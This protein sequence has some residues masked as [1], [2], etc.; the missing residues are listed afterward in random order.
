MLYGVQVN[1]LAILASAVASFIIGW[2]WYGPLFGK[3]WM[4]LNNYGKKEIDAAK[5]KGMMGMLIINFI[6]TLVTAYV[7]ATLLSALEINAVGQA[8]QLAFWLWLGFLAAT[9][10]L[11][12]VLW[13]GKPWG[14]FILNGAYWLVILE[15][16]A[17]ILSVW[18]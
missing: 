9:T 11:G 18:D 4:K 15:V 14:L 8:V 5:K 7:F 13:D 12:A 3:T 17:V 6:G 2:I 1:W 10:L 16:M